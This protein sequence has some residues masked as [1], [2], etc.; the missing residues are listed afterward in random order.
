[1]STPLVLETFKEQ[2]MIYLMAY[3]PVFEEPIELFLATP[4]SEYREIF[5]IFS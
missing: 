3:F 1:V 4:S 2:N 5:L